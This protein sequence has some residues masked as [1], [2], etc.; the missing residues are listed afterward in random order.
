MDKYF[1]CEILYKIHQKD[2]DCEGGVVGKLDQWMHV[3]REFPTMSNM[4]KVTIVSFGECISASEKH[5]HIRTVTAWVNP[6][7][8]TICINGDAHVHRAGVLLAIQVG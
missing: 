2:I 7:P 6:P 8:G 1:F 5:Y 3:G 4:Y